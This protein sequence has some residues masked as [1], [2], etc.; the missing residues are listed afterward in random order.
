VRPPV[1]TAVME[2]KKKS[3]EEQFWEQYSPPKWTQNRYVWWASSILGIGLAIY[4]TKA[5]R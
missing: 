5:G 4:S 2:R 3:L 1:P